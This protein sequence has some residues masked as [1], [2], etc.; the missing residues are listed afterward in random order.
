MAS[1][2]P[3]PLSTEQFNRIMIRIT[4]NFDPVI[5]KKLNKFRSIYRDLQPTG[6]FKLGEGYV[7]KVHTF[8]PGLDDQAALLKWSA[9]STYRAPGTNGQ[10]D[11][12]FDPCK[13]TAYMLGYGFKTET[14]S[15]WKTTRRSPNYC[16]KDFMY[17][18]QFAQQLQMILES[19]G[20]VALQIWEN[21]G[22]EMYMNYANKF[23]ATAEATPSTLFTYDPFTSTQLTVPKNTVIS[24]LT[25]K[26]LDML[27]QLLALQCKD[28]A[29]AIESDMP[30]YGLVL[31]PYDWDDMIRRDAALREDYRFANP[32]LLVDGI[33]KL[34]RFRGFAMNFDLLA[35]RFKL[36]SQDANGDMVFERVLPFKEEATT[37]GS[38]W[39][40]DQDYLK[41]EYTLVNI[42]L[43]DVYEKQVPPVTPGRIAGA[44]FGTTPNN[45]GE[46][47]WIN[48]PDV[49]NNI[50]QEKGFFFSRFTAFSKP[51]VNNEYAISMLVKRCPQTPAVLCEPCADATAGAKTVTAAVAIDPTGSLSYYQVEVTISDANGLTCEGTKSITVTY[52]DGTAVTA[53]I[54]DDSEA[55]TKYTLTFASAANW[56]ALHGGISTV[57]CA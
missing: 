36:A 13:Y 10:T 17:E 50:L 43:K 15:G 52:V 49:E 25:P 7:R 16:I 5:Q 30:Y 8:Y 51:L 19:F 32:D 3:I 35:P 24:T 55:P 23:V 6:P 39:N 11:P 21:F 22:R 9:E 34:T 28:G 42:I 20:D 56:V 46:L 14:Y 40:A 27:Y 2:N 53:L 47:K 29:L 12:G 4:E 26:H 33:G 38:R 57:T 18:W 45:D 48:I 37:Q 54:A 1:G 44:T 31:H 41:A